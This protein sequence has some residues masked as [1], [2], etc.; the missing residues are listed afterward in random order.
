V[1][2][3]GIRPLARHER[4]TPKHGCREGGWNRGRSNLSSCRDERFCVSRELTTWQRTR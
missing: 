2:R 1:N 4:T 3:P